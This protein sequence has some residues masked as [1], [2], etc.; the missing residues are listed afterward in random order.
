MVRL[1]LMQAI[2]KVASQWDGDIPM[3]EDCNG[4]MVSAITGSHCTSAK[5]QQVQ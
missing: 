3:N 1:V 5:Q 2:T 4:V